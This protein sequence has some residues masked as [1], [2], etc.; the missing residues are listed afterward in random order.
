MFYPSAVDLA[1]RKDGFAESNK[2]LRVI[3]WSRILVY[4]GSIQLS[5]RSMLGVIM[6]SYTTAAI[7]ENPECILKNEILD[8]QIECPGFKYFVPIGELHKLVNESTIRKALQTIYPTL[9]DRDQ[10]RLQQ[11]TATI[12]VRSKRLFAILVCGENAVRQSIWEFIEEGITDADL[13]LCRT[14]HE[15]GYKT[16]LCRSGHRNCRGMNYQLCGHEI[17]VTSRWRKDSLADLDRRQWFFQAPEFRTLHGEIPHLDLATNVVMPFTEDDEQKEGGL[18]AGGYSEVWAV[19]MHPDHHNLLYSTDPRGPLLAIKRLISRDP[20]QFKRETNFLADLSKQ[21]HPHLIQLLATYSLRKQYHLVFP[22]AEENLREYWVSVGHPF[23]NM[24]T[25]LWFLQQICGL[26][27]AL[28]A[29]HNFRVDSPAVEEA[30][31]TFNRFSRH[32]GVKLENDQA[33]KFG[34]HGDL[35]PENIL[36][37][38]TSN[39]SAG[40]GILQITDFGLGRFHRFESRSIQDPRTITGSPT[41]APPEIALGRAVSRAYDIWSLGCIFLEFVTWLLEGSSSL[42][43]FNARREMVAEDGVQDDLYFTLCTPARPYNARPNATIR[44]GV[45]EWIEHLRQ[46]TRCSNMTND[47]LDVIQHDMLLIDS[48]RRIRSHD[49]LERLEEILS[50]GKRSKEYLLGRNVSASSQHFGVASPQAK[51]A[52]MPKV[53]FL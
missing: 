41:Y 19:R 49:L 48:N 39:N 22:Y 51:V 13:P 26:V 24:D 43:V 7:A 42:D 10:R 25:C 27:S 2:R 40:P 33:E 4:S 11:Y 21:N 50:E 29:I 46:S 23:W 3:L 17:E 15:T 1:F 8:S 31:D 52:Q 6:S 5:L 38:R 53:R 16:T 34:R 18:R 44:K 20:L 30:N 37:S 47:F 32:R 9:A 28:N 35:K 36:R 45:T 14:Q 12:S